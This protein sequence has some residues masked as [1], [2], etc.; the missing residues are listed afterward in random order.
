MATSQFSIREDS[1]FAIA[2]AQSLASVV[3]LQNVHTRKNGLVNHFHVQV[4]VISDLPTNSTF[5]FC[6]GKMTSYGATKLYNSNGVQAY[7]VIFSSDHDN[8]FQMTTK[9]AVPAGW[10]VLDHTWIDS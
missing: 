7:N 2:A 9:E 3:E 6:E 10:Y 5:A 4:H 8:Y 1:T